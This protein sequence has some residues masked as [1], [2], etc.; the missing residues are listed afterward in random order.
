M[1]VTGGHT[2]GECTVFRDTGLPRSSHIET[3]VDM[4]VQAQGVEFRQQQKTVTTI[5]SYPVVGGAT[6]TRISSR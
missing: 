4:L 2:N 3:L 5:E 1:T 6:P